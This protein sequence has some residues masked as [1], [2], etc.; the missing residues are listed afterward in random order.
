[1]LNELAVA[2]CMLIIMLLD[3]HPI[4]NHKNCLPLMGDFSCSHHNRAPQNFEENI[5]LVIFLL[6]CFFP[7]NFLFPLKNPNFKQST[8]FSLAKDVYVT[9]SW[10]LLFMKTKDSLCILYFCNFTSLTKFF[11]VVICFLFSHV[12]LK[13]Y[14]IIKKIL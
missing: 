6:C 10:S 7:H 11:R 9:I 5:F 1:M 14:I 2:R 12:I 3:F 4:R 13:Q 8:I